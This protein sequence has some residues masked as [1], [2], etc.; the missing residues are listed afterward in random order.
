MSV[1][2]KIRRAEE[3]Y[4]RRNYQNNYTYRSSSREK[5][6]PTLMNRLIKRL[7]VCFIIYGVFYMVENRDY[8]LSEEFR[9]QVQ[10]IVPVLAR[11]VNKK[12]FLEN[13]MPICIK[14]L[15]DPVYAI[16]QNTC[17]IMK[18]LYDIFKGE[19]FEKKLLSKLS[20][21]AK[22]DSYLIRITVVML[23]KEFLVDEY[24]LEF[25]EK[26]LFPFIVKLADDKIPNVRQTCSV[27]IKKLVRL[28]KNKDVIKECKSM[29]DELKRDRDLEVVYAI[30]DN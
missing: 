17:K 10:E 18:R 12:L 23:I 24:E 22:S 9:N 1:E 21:M 8:Y 7:I 26:K 3:I 29:I 25:M 19:E 14:W 20:P 2:E 6:Q 16:R 28:S 5:K 4:N 27:V 13:I 30:T 11:I 15:T